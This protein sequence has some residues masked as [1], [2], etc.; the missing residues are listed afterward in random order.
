MT[1][2]L[3]HGK[4]SRTCGCAAV[5][6]AGGSGT[7]F[8]PMSRRSKPKQYL[9][10]A[11]AGKSLIQATAD[12]VKPLVGEDGVLVIT[13]GDQAPLVH[14]QLPHAAIMVEPLARNT[15]ACIGLAA[16]QV[17]QD[18]GDVPMICL[19]ADHLITAADRLLQIYR[20]A[21]ELARSED[22]LITIGIKPTS[23][24]TG[25]GYIKR[26]PIRA[27]CRAQV[28]E[29]AKFVEKPDRA[30]AEQYLA[31]G[32]FFW[33]SGMFVW[34]PTVIL[35]A[36]NKHLPAL[37]AEL[38]Q[39]EKAL[40]GPDALDVCS[41]A[42]SALKPVSIDTGVLEKA[43]RVVMVSGEDLGWSDIGSWASWADIV[44]RGLSAESN[45]IQGEGV[46]VESRGCTIVGGKR[47]IALVGLE[48][49]IVVDTE[50]CTLI[51]SAE[52]SQ[53]VK[54]LVDLL[55]ETKYKGLL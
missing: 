55:G 1:E 36:I 49:A 47:L 24:E 42:Y 14:E 44:R 25:Y 37:S 10:L 53:D 48:N 6:M 38:S 34:R 54:K 40:S 13:A 51:C 29:V 16:L 27:D 23:P 9:P 22:A 15:A 5:I 46:S 28:F 30:T 31:S 8:W 21:V 4:L 7:R 17:L 18:A 33:N 12:R 41:A 52:K 39:I 43:E 35:Q 45:F 32:D 26:G 20:D 2:K 19:P 11:E 50:D 3:V